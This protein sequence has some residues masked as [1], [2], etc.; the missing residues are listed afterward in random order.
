MSGKKSQHFSQQRFKTIWNF[1]SRWSGLSPLFSIWCGR[2]DSNPHDL[3]IASPSSCQ[4]KSS[5]AAD[6]GKTGSVFSSR[7]R[8]FPISI[9]FRESVAQRCTRRLWGWGLMQVFLSKTCRTFQ[10]VLAVS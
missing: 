3:A 9:P 7:G 10:A 6:P 1:E 2:G 4:G 5:T 8:P